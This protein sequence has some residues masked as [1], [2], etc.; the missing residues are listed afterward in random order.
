[1]KDSFRHNDHLPMFQVADMTV[2][3]LTINR[4]RERVVD[5]SKPFI[6]T[7]ISIMIKKPDSQVC[8]I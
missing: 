1:M 8:F 5:F 3:P 4:V 2:A 6:T 7:G